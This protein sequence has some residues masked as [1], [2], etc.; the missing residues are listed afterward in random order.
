M[1]IQP[2]VGKKHENIHK[3]SYSYH[4]YHSHPCFLS[5]S[6]SMQMLESKEMEQQGERGDTWKHHDS[7]CEGGSQ[8]VEV[9]QRTSGQRR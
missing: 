7:S 9:E 2:S 1:V 5:L 3:I 6:S 8:L 4:F